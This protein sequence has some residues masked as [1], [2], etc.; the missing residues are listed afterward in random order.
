MR[1]AKGEVRL[2]VY[3]GC[4]T[5]DKGFRLTHLK[6]GGQYLEDDSDF[7]QHVTTAAGYGIMSVKANEQV[8]EASMGDY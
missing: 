5:L 4:E 2:Q 7:Y 8:S 1:N 6:K 3:K